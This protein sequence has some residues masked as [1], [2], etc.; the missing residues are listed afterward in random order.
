MSTLLEDYAA[1]RSQ[2]LPKDENYVEPPP[3]PNHVYF[4]LDRLRSKVLD[5]DMEDAF[6]A[7]QKARF[8]ERY[9]E[10]IKIGLESDYKAA[11][12]L[13]GE[14]P[15]KATD[16]SEG[17]FDGDEIVVPWQQV[18]RTV[19]Q[20]FIDLAVPDNTRILLQMSPKAY[21]ALHL[22]NMVGETLVTVLH[23]HYPH[24]QIEASPNQPLRMSIDLSGESP[25]EAGE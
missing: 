7:F 25:S 8:D 6:E 21:T 3:N 17:W 1:F 13:S 4:A 9:R 18:Y 23:A 2:M 22:T 11:F 14:S 12:N 16:I 5:R 20:M 15:D 24:M 10:S 19:S